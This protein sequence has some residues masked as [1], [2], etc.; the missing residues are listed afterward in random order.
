MNNEVKFKIINSKRLAYT[1][2]FLYDLKYYVHD[3][4]TDPTK[5]VYSFQ[6]TP[7]LNEALST[8]MKIKNK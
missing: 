6:D 3:H 8:I 1:L 2:A 4:N 7:L 5:K